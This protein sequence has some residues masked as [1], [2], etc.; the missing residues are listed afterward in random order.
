[1]VAARCRAVWLGSKMRGSPSGQRFRR[2][3]PPPTMWATGLRVAVRA[4][5]RQ[6]TQSLSR[7]PS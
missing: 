6:G 5:R 3:S 1:M 2:A 4:D 7:S